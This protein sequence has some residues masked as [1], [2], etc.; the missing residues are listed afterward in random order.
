MS[1][2]YFNFPKFSLND[3]QD[4][5][6]VSEALWMIYNESDSSGDAQKILESANKMAPHQY[7]LI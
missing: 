4:I 2:S 6:V 1:D 5:G 3:H 7:K